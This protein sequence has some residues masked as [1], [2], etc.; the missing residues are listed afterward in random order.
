MS[1]ISRLLDFSGLRTEI[2]TI[3]NTIHNSNSKSRYPTK[4]MPYDT[5]SYKWVCSTCGSKNSM[6]SRNCSKPYCKN[7]CPPEE[8]LRHMQA[9]MSRPVKKVHFEGEDGPGKESRPGPE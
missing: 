7:R 2:N 3:F 9:E 6:R 4:T 5:S 1:F 8:W